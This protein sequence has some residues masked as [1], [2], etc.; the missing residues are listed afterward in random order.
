M[1]KILYISGTRADFGLMR[2]TL[3]QIN[4]DMCMELEV[5]ATGMHL[6]DKFG[7]S[8]D[9]I[10]DEDFKLHIINQTFKEDSPEAMSIFVGKLIV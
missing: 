7:N 1:R 5:I 10:E 6:M 9:E 3:R 4:E 8:I 2:N